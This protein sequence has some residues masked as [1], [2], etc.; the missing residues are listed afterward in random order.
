M[1]IVIDKEL[2]TYLN[3]GLLKA[4]VFSEFSKEKVHAPIQESS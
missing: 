2:G 4:W 1:L 3:V